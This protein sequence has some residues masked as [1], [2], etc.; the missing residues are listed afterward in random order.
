MRRLETFGEVRSGVQFRKNNVLHAETAQNARVVFG[1]CFSDHALRFE[2]LQIQ[3]EKHT[4]LN[5]AATRHDAHFEIGHTHR[6]ERLFITGVQ[7]H[8][9]LQFVLQPFH[10]H[11][12]VVDAHDIPAQR[13]ET[14]CYGTAETSQSDH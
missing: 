11:R 3:D 8:D 7:Q 6:S 1:N 14:P 12:V 9:V 10:N 13:Q 2:V 5:A 4:A